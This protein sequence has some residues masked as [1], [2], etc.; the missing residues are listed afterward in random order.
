[1]KYGY[2]RYA[3]AADLLWFVVERT[4]TKNSREAET[5]LFGASF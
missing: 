1:M 5:C 4:F 3:L 2:Y